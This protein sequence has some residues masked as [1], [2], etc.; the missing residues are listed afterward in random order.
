[1]APGTVSADQ[2]RLLIDPSTGT[3]PERAQV[4]VRAQVPE[5]A[6]VRARAHPVL[7]S[8]PLDYWLYGTHR[9]WSKP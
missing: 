5:R 2:P 8:D 9:S 3:V 7:S 4:P 1:M 6:Q